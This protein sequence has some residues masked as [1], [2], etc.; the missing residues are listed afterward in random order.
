MQQG[1][2]KER[3]RENYQEVLPCR[4]LV[5]GK[6]WAGTQCLTERGERE[7]GKERVTP[8]KK[9]ER[10]ISKET[11]TT[12]KTHQEVLS[13]RRWT[14]SN[15]IMPSVRK[16]TRQETPEKRETGIFIIINIPKT[17]TKKSSHADIWSWG[18]VR[19]NPMSMGWGGRRGAARTL[20]PLLRQA[21]T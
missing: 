3:A 1:R 4:H 20:A 5:L 10:N 9:S 14:G 13:C 21:S 11:D 18:R 7:T 17:L 19:R 6:G 2:G 16:E 8:W 15:Y 12:R